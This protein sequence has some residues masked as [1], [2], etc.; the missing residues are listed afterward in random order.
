MAEEQN[1]VVSI[2]IPRDILKEIDR[3]AAAEGRTRSNFLV[4]LLK[5]LLKAK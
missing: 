4:Q 1:E 5:T 3:Q 2:R